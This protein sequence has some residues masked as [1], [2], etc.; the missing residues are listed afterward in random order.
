MKESS[1]LKG[2]EEFEKFVSLKG[3][4]PEEALA[5]AARKLYERAW[6]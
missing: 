4:T 1:S 3:K 2:K 5:E 6:R